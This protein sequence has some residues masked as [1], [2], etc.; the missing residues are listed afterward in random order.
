MSLASALLALRGASCPPHLPRRLLHTCST[1]LGLRDMFVKQDDLNKRPS[2]LEIKT[3]DL[4]PNTPTLG[5]RL[6]RDRQHLFHEDNRQSGYT[7]GRTGDR[8]STVLL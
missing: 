3:K 8:V 7:M 5:Q 1:H 6:M 4:P 2:A